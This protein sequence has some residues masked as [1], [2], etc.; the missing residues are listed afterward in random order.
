MELGNVMRRLL[1]VIVLVS[2]FGCAASNEQSPEGAPSPQE[3]CIDGC[4]NTYSSCVLECDK[5][6][7][8][9][10]KLDLCFQ[11][12]KE[13]WAECKEDCTKAGNLQ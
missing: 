8:I 12:C 5:T 3:E 7:A 4:L 9:G 13:N 1:L 2:L 11:Q 10:P 6:V